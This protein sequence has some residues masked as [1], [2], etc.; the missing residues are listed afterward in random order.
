MRR[1]LRRIRAWASRFR[2]M[3]PKVKK[4]GWRYYFD[5]EFR[6]RCRNRERTLKSRRLYGNNYSYKRKRFIR[7]YLALHGNSCFWCGKRMRMEEITVDH[8]KPVAQGGKTEFSNMRLIHESCRVERD[9]L[10]NSGQL[11]TDASPQV[12]Q[13]P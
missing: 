11:S 12:R 6:K 8:I 7:R 4:W 1:L 3:Y 13:A 9:R 5:W 10:I 2:M